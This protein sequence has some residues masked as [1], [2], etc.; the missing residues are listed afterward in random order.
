M[1]FNNNSNFNKKANFTEVK[2]GENKPVLEVELNELQQIQ[3]E[4]RADIIRDTIPSGFTQL[5]EID[6]DYCLYNEN[7]IRLKTDSVAYVNGYR[8]NIPMGTVI[9]LPKAPKDKI[10]E[11][12]V[13]LE[14]WRQEVTNN[15]T[16]TEY[17]GDDQPLVDNSIQDSR[18]PIETTRRVAL[19]WRIRCVA[20]VN[21]N[22]HKEGLRKTG[23]N[24]EPYQCKGQGGNTSIENI[25]YDDE[26][27]YYGQCGSISNLDI[28]YGGFRP[29]DTGLYICGNGSEKAKKDLKTVDGYCFAIPM[30]KLTR[31]PAV[32]KAKPFEYTKLNPKVDYSKFS[33]LMQE[34]KVER[35]IS[36]NIQG[37]SL[38]NLINI[39]TLLTNTY[40]SYSADTNILVA[41]STDSS[42][43]E[44]VPSSL[45]N[46]KPNTTYSCIYKL[47]DDGPVSIEIGETNTTS[48]ITGQLLLRQ[49]HIN[50]NN[51]VEVYTF[52]TPSDCGAN[53]GL[54][55]YDTTGKSPKRLQI[56]VLEGDWRTKKEIPDFF[57]GLKSLGEE[58]GNLIT[59][60]NGILDDYTYDVN[61]GNQK[62]KSFPSLTHVRSSNTLVPNN[63]EANLVSGSTTTPITK[64]GTN[65]TTTGNETI[66]FTKIK[67][68]TLQNLVI[69]DI[70]SILGTSG[71]GK[72]DRETIGKFVK[73]TTV[74]N[75]ASY[76]TCKLKQSLSFIKSNTTYTII[77]TILKNTI[78]N[79]KG[80]TIAGASDPFYGSEIKRVLHD[81]TF[82]LSVG[83]KVV[84]FTTDSD[85]SGYTGLGFGFPEVSSRVEA[86]EVFYIGNVIL[87][88]GDYTN[89]PLEELPYIEG[90]KS[91]GEQEN[92]TI[93]IYSN[94]KNIFDGKLQRGHW[95]NGGLQYSDYAVAN[96]NFIP[97]KPNTQYT[98]TIQ[99]Y[100]GIIYVA[101]LDYSLNQLFTHKIV[102]GATITIT[103]GVFLKF[104]TENLEKFKLSTDTQ[105]Q[106]EEGNT[107]TSY[108]PYKEYVQNIHLKEP[109][110]SLPN[111]VCDEI[112]GNKI[113]RRVKKVV[114]DGSETWNNGGMTNDTR[115]ELYIT[116]EKV[117]PRANCNNNFITM[118]YFSDRFPTL[119]DVTGLDKWLIV[120][121]LG[122]ISIALPKSELAEPYQTSAKEGLSKN[123]T[124]LYYEL[125]KEW[126]SK[127]PTT[128]YYELATP[129]EEYL[130]N[131]YEKESIKTYQLDAPLR[132]L[133]NGVKDEIKDGVLIRRCGEYVMRGSDDEGWSYFD[134][135]RHGVNTY[136]A[137]A[138]INNC[139]AN[140]Y[141]VT[142]RLKYHRMDLW[143]P[144]TDIEGL[145][146][147]SQ[148]ASI[149]VRL[150]KTRLS[151]GTLTAFKN[152][153]KQNPLKVI[154]QL[155]APTV[156][157][158]NEVSPQ[159]TDFSLQRQFGEGNYL[160]EL[161][162]GVRD[163]IE[164]G[165]VIRRTGVYVLD[166]SQSLIADTHTSNKFSEFANGYLSELPNKK[167]CP[168]DSLAIVCD[169]LKALT[170]DEFL[171][172]TTNS[173]T[174]NSLVSDATKKGVCIKVHQS[175]LNTKDV[176]GLKE[177][178]THNPVTI[179]YELETPV[180]ED[181]VN[182]YNYYYPSQMPN[183]YCG[184]L[185][186]G[187]GR[188]YVNTLS[189]LPSIDPVVIETEFRHISGGDK[190]EDCR[191]KKDINGCS[192]ILPRSKTVNL[193]PTTS[194][195][196]EVGTSVNV[197][198]MTWEEAKINPV[199]I[200]T[201][202]RLIHP[203]P[204]K[205]NTQYTISNT[206]GLRV[207]LKEFNEVGIGI[208]DTSWIG[209]SPH[210]FTTLPNT[211][212]LVVMFSRTG[213]LAMSNKD[214]EISQTMLCEGSSTPSSYVPFE[215]DTLAFE[216][217][218]NHEIEDF[219]HLVSL[220]GFDYT[221]ILNKSFDTLLRGEL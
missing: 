154:F 5:G 195:F 10:R 130:V 107:Y 185:Y 62:L 8:I 115:Q 7:Q 23:E 208:K 36:E 123:S 43:W 104:C 211:K 121:R 150:L 148:N 120:N 88:E 45:I 78:P 158:L 61:D 103:N 72:I 73:Y 16:L 77:F 46:I 215:V 191:H 175:L 137:Q 2:F 69:G 70:D 44:N 200:N 124:K 25:T 33:N 172:E 110:R 19:K 186:V 151:E 29:V 179:I 109:L 108:E 105:V 139:K 91:I 22:A 60:K 119:T 152:F 56:M 50:K 18:Y 15:D 94:G 28:R 127:N 204:V 164:N 64:L 65:L 166:G 217:V 212:F 182:G 47:L 170:N 17:G 102:S 157:P 74:E 143:N 68:R 134:S 189:K 3:N 216:N 112:V 178:L 97:V 117:I 132:S 14:V 140:S 27:Y 37:R 32:G 54:K 210:T 55:V 187:D 41:P 207:A 52:T 87:L 125:A 156:V 31:K 116:P 177:W 203:I 138:Y 213:D 82:D 89:V 142:D 144:N 71:I 30:F 1:S 168:K 201:R 111:G 183:T 181:I 159:T 136:Y 9:N 38:V 184:S 190:V 206:S 199:L 176:A 219:R 202:F 39:P 66:E 165:K 205:P 193:L 122:G 149:Q 76:I 153:F 98:I 35:V 218:E 163:T 173:I 24:W 174:S 214:V 131:V 21:F 141:L 192:K 26:H 51:R 58:E 93:N 34:D 194:R 169:R 209:N 20:D 75:G 84:K 86:G 100:T 48:T 90:I 95:I 11:D 81:P 128:L 79:Y 92:N 160:R 53:V 220:S 13:F 188:N 146:C 57:T 6:Y 63:I 118:N 221:N 99:N 133:P 96:V 198:N 67:G 161:P 80:I 145:S 101:E 4:A 114:L 129:V 196:V 42:P 135:I 40:Y 171:I 162:N 106:I 83:T 49:S 197:V 59:V 12:F 85:I 167:V 180:T 126:L 147:H 113:I 155:T